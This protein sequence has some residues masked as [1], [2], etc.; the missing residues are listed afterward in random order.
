LNQ[1]LTSR[2]IAEL[3]MAMLHSAFLDT[4]D[5]VRFF[6][7]FRPVLGELLARADAFEKISR[8]LEGNPSS[9]ANTTG[10]LH[11]LLSRVE[12]IVGEFKSLVAV[13]ERCRTPSNS[14]SE[15]ER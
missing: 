15:K 12:Q 3:R 1:P 13:A 10:Q 9:Y 4:A 14:T 2:D 6:E 7:T 8:L 11:G 5:V